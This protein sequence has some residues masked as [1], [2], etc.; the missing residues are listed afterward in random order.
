MIQEEANLWFE[1]P[2]IDLAYLYSSSMH[3]LMMNLFFM[4]ILPI[5]LILGFI[6]I[7]L[8]YI[9]DKYMVFRIYAIPRASG[10]ELALAMIHFFDLSLIFITVIKNYKKN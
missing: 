5:G 9:I 8:T 10:Q 7:S 6:S 3:T 1:G 4:T 2:G